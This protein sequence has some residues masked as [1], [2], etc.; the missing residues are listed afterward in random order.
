MVDIDL[1]T[2]RILLHYVLAFVGLTVLVFLESAL[3][4]IP[5]FYGSV[6]KVSLCVVFLLALYAPHVASIYLVLAI[7]IIF[8]T[9]QSNPFG[10]TSSLYLIILLVMDWRRP[11][12]MAADDVIIWFEFILMVMALTLYMFIVFMIYHG[13]WPP[14]S[15]MIFQ[16]GFTAMLFPLFNLI[17]ILARQFSQ[18]IGVFK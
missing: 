13:H 16:I 1:R 10:Y 18:Y 8:D 11:T 6:P 4:L 14:V 15:E 9:I 7:G 17:A 3:G 5:T 2:D 12:L